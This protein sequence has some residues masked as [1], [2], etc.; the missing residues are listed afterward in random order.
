MTTDIRFKSS[1]NYTRLIVQFGMLTS[2]LDVNIAAV[3][4]CGFFYFTTLNFD[5]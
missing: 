5:F 1:I 2:V 3:F 4:F